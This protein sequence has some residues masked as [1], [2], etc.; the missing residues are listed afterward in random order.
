M[1]RKYASRQSVEARAVEVMEKGLGS[2]KEAPSPSQ[3][4]P[5]PTTMTATAVTAATAEHIFKS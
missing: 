2:E 3:T 5:P 4:P 1:R